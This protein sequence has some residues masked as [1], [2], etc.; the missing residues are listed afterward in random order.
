VKTF[1]CSS[2]VLVDK[3]GE[4]Y[5]HTGAGCLDFCIVFPTISRKQ[6]SENSR[7]ILDFVM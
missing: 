5:H 2:F 3:N 7:I 4:E 6:Q 1:L